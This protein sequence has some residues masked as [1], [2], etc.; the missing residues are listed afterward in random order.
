MPSLSVYKNDLDYS[1]APGIFPSMECLRHRPETVRRL[2]LH[3][4]AS[5][6][7][8]A[9]RLRAL[10]E[11]HGVRVEEADRVLA[12]ISGK[13]NCFAAAVFAK[14]SDDLAPDRPHVVLHNPGDS[15]NVGTILRTALGFG[16][17]DAALIRPCVDLF[18]PRTVRAS[19]GSLFSLRV[20]VYEDFEE[21]RRDFPDRPLYPFMLDASLPL[22]EVLREKRPPDWTLIFGNEGRGLPA[23]F[24]AL[25]QAVRIESNDR[26]DSLNLAVAAAI[27]IYGFTRPGN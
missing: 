18:D 22:G 13:E 8:G 7:E 1:Y 24:S 6:R 21:Y 14:F 10:A 5:G 23:A 20:R 16:V 11:E 27:G 26:V 25:G 9:D 12:R 3:S 15:G 2:L 4:S 19:M 17:E